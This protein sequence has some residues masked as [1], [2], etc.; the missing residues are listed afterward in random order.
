MN[1]LRQPFT[2]I[3][4][5]RAAAAGMDE[6]GG[7]V[8]VVTGGNSGIGRAFVER[9]A[10]E[11]AKVIACGRSDVTLQEVQ[12]QHSGVEVFRCDIT[13]APEVL[14]LAEPSWKAMGRLMS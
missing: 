2:L 7:R 6:W 10:A 14:A 9:L 11:N 8:V 3:R 5:P 12:N 1:K 13:A 4:K